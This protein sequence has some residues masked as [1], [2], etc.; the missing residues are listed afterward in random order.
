MDP[1]LIIMIAQK[2]RKFTT[3]FGLRVGDLTCRG[4]SGRIGFRWN[5][6]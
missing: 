2:I 5:F 6:D 3:P 1:F 4:I